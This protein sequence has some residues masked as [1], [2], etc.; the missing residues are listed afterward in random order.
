MFLSAV[1]AEPDIPL[2]SEDF[3]RALSLMCNKIDAS[4]CVCEFCI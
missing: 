2:I 3:E 4:T 1:E